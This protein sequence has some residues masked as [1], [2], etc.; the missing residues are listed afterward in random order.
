M[1]EVLIRYLI[2]AHAG[3]GF[4]ALTVGAVALS[5]KKGR[6]TH[7]F[8]GKVF[9]LS[10][11]LSSM[12]SVIISSQP[13][14][15]NVFLF[16]IGILTIYLVTTGYRCLKYRDQHKSLLIDYSLTIVMLIF[17]LVLLSYVPIVAGKINLLFTIFGLL[18]LSLTIQDLIA[19]RNRQKLGDNVLKMHIGKISGAYIASVTAFV[20]VNSLIPGIYGWI[21]PGILGTFYIIYWN[22]RLKANSL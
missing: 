8:S 19:Y 20:V 3:F 18:G 16:C 10:M 2:F 9:A 13:K 12:L 15:S 1:T 11:L 21:V 17:S 22:R 14:H 5:T 4:V 7:K 6:K